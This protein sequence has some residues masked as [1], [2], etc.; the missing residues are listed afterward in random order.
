MCTREEREREREKRREEALI[1][2]CL[3]LEGL[4]PPAASG[5]CPNTFPTKMDEYSNHSMYWTTKFYNW[6]V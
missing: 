1:Y 3:L 4:K 2:L 5:S 6:M